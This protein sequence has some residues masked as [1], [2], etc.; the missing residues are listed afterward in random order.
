MRMAEKIR[1]R[2]SQMVKIPRLLKK[3]IR[4]ITKEV[5]A[6]CLR[7]ASAERLELW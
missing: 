2:L 6:A 3:R 1:G 4:V 7:E 5:S